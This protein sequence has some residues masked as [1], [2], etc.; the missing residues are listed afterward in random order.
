MTKLVRRL[1]TAVIAAAALAGLALLAANLYVQSPGPQQQIRQRLGAVLG[2]PVEVARAVFSPWGGLRIDGIRAIGPDERPVLRAE[3]FQMGV[4]LLD[5]MRGKITVTSLT[6]ESP[7][8]MLAQDS[9]GRWLWQKVRPTTESIVIPGAD[10]ADLDP[11]DEPAPPVTARSAPA[12]G[13]APPPAASSPAPAPAGAATLAKPAI[14]AL[15]FPPGF[16]GMKM[17]H[18]NLT[19]L[20]AKGRRVAVL[21][22]VDLDLRPIAGGAPTDFM[23]RITLERASFDDGRVQVT[24]FHS[25]IRCNDGVVTLPDGN[26]KLAEGRLIGSLVIRPMDPG[27]PYEVEARIQGVSLGHLVADAGGDGE[28]ATG[29]LEGTL[30]LRGL[31]A[32][33]RARTGGGK[34]RL[35]DGQFR[36]SGLLRTLGD[37]S[38][39]EELRKPEFKLATLD[40]RVEGRKLVAEPLEFV[41]ANL[42]LVARGDCF[43]PKGDLDL[44]ARLIIAPQIARQL[45]S[46]VASN[47]RES[48]DVP[49]ERYIDF[50]IGGTLAHPDTDLWAKTLSQPVQSVLSRFFGR[51]K[52]PTEPEVEQESAAPPKPKG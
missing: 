7:E 38:R 46:L 24:N 48:P 13:S 1:I 16:A 8:V 20:D 15:T 5:L 35:L 34:L 47:F 6:L 17:R 22:E 10:P 50:K 9:E 18:A 27:S 2:M 23:G 28:F 30:S 37:R 19:F 29:K 40:Y 14:R 51:S 4:A 49:G 11:A 26:G 12:S 21:E 31:G 32:D 52:K 39:I 33:P 3:T 42:R 44:G 36:R 45:P 43:L 41:S 25:S